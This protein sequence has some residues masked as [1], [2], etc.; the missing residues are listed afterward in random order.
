MYL[1][2][3]VK[4]L[5]ATLTEAYK[6]QSL[7]MRMMYKSICSFKDKYYYDIVN[8]MPEEVLEREVFLR[9]QLGGE[10]IH[11]ASCFGE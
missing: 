8:N 2:Q 1:K 6:Q 3:R 7:Y 5:E 9:A 10:M 4:R 11:T